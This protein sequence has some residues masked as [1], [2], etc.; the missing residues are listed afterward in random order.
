MLWHDWVHDDDD[1]QHGESSIEISEIECKRWGGGGVEKIR[2][3]PISYRFS[4]A[5]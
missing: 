5:I 1:A 2:W 3:L 4:S